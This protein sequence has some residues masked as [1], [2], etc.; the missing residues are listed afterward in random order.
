[1]EKRKYT[2]IQVLLPES[3][4][5]LAEG[6]PS[7]NTLCFRDKQAVKG[8]LSVSE[9]KNASWRPEF[10]RGSKD[11][12]GK[13]LYRETL[14]QSRRM[15]FGAYRWKTN[16]CGI[17]CTSQEGRARVKYPSYTVLRLPC[18]EK[19]IPMTTPWRKIS[20]PSSKQSAFT[21]TGL[22]LFLRPMR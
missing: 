9:E 20:F 2:H 5:I 8:C 11:G 13:M 3:K 21:G 12:Q 15:R 17:F 14:W 7:G 18:Q 16:C 1:M 10:Y 22:L 6:K 19:K 4:A